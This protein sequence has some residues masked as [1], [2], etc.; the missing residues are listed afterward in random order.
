M[1]EF[2][3]YGRADFIAIPQAKTDEI[4]DLECLGRNIVA[5]ICA[6]TSATKVLIPTPNQIFAISGSE[7]NR[8][9]K[10]GECR[11]H[12]ETY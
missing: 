8:V 2:L 12:L 6:Q 7:I 1:P 3:P 5:H 4:T 10:L 9:Q 11:N